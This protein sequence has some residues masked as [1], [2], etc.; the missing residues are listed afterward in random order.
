VI[1]AL[2]VSLGLAAAADNPQAMR[3]LHEWVMAVDAHVAGERDDPLAT[4][5]AWTINDVEL[6]RPYLEA[7][8]GVPVNTS[9]RTLRRQM[10]SGNDFAAIKRLA[11]GRQARSSFDEFRRR[12]A[13]YH[14]DIAL[15]HSMPVI[16]KAPVP[17]QQQPAWRR[18]EPQPAIDVKTADARLEHFEVANPHWT[19]ARAMLETLPVKPQRDPMVAQ[20][21]R[22]IGAHFARQHNAADALRHFE[23]AREFVADDPGVQFGEACLQETLGSPS[24]QNFARTTMLPNGLVL[25]G[26]STPSTHFRRA[27]S[28][29]KRAIATRPDFVDAQL[30]LG[31]VLIELRQHDMALQ[32]LAK[33]IAGTRDPVLTY[34]AHLFSGDAAMALSRPS[35]ARASYERALASHPAAQAARIGLA[36]ALRASGDRSAAVSA[37]MITLSTPLESRDVSD[38]PWWQYYEGDAANVERLLTELR[39]PFTAPAR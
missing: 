31:R 17:R 39:R 27:E 18:G 4:V 38:D 29:L 19:V 36:A 10:I 20:W 2:I 22:A 35:E 34:Y 9:P 13:I 33:V 21:Y 3:W 37:V 14:T 7:F 24:V 8:A 11:G 15:L 26:V 5:A 23:R 25:L 1:N 12:A 30:R 32:Q 6:M 16:V 28:L